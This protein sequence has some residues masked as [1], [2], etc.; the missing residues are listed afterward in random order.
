MTEKEPTLKYPYSCPS[1]GADLERRGAII[2]W[3]ESPERL[4]GHI[5]PGEEHGVGLAL[6]KIEYNPQPQL[7]CADCGE[8]LEEKR[9]PI[10]DIYLGV[11]CEI[12]DSDE[13][14]D[15]SQKE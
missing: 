9:F 2:A 5:E 3:I 13:G 6:D 11:E 12:E 7:Q 15:N 14:K 10:E 1:C 4:V 8:H